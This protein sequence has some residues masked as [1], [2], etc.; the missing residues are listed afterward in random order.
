MLRVVSISKAQ[1]CQRTGRAGR[2][3]PGLCYRLY[4]EQVHDEKF[5]DTTV[6]EILR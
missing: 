3:G 6:P 4:K 1:A 2:E 5:L